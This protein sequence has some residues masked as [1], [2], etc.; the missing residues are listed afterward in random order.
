MVRPIRVR[1][2]AEMPSVERG[3]IVMLEEHPD[4]TVISASADSTEASE[5]FS[6]VQVDLKYA[7]GVEL[8]SALADPSDSGAPIVL[9]V[10]YPPATWDEPLSS[11]VAILPVD[12]SS[13]SLVAAVLA[14][15]SGLSVIDPDFARDSRLQWVADPRPNVSE[16][17][18]LTPREHE[19]LELVSEGLPN[20]TIALRLGISEHTVKFHLGSL[21]GKLGAGSRT[22][23]VTLA[24]RQGFLTI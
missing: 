12:S 23:A 8:S 24:T 10:D 3:L 15:A 1:V 14:V 2:H 13:D 11:P 5:L 20:K 7:P 18:I 9:L 4:I 17:T 22:E 19:V 6:D 16:S 21:M